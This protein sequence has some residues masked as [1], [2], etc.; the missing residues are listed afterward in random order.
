M[1]LRV[2]GWSAEEMAPAD[3]PSFIVLSVLPPCPPE[4]FVL[5]R[6][7]VMIDCRWT[8]GVAAGCSHAFAFFIEKCEHKYF[9]YY[10]ATYV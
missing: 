6:A 8:T 1:I 9:I 3:W 7:L 5:R 10:I 2:V 4:R